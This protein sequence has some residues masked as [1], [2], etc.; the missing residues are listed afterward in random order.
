MFFLLFFKEMRYYEVILTRIINC[1]PL[2]VYRVLSLC[3]KGEKI[4]LHVGKGMQAK[5]R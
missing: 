1:T 4:I 3:F 2:N 5:L